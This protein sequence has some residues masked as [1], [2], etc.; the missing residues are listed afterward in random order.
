L[1]ATE[2]LQAVLTASVSRRRMQSA[3]NNAERHVEMCLCRSTEVATD[4]S[5]YISGKWT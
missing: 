3:V 2:P 4:F 1:S 5:A